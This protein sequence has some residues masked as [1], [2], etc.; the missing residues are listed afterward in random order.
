MGLERGLLELVLGQQ[1][2][3]AAHAW[4]SEERLYSIQGG[5]VGSHMAGV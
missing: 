3:D 1:R 4:S 2:L 5:S